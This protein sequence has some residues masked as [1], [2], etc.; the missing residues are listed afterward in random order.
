MLHRMS[1]F[2]A[3]RDMLHCGGRASL[4]GHCGHGWTC[5]L[6]RPVAI[7]TRQPQ[8]GALKK[9]LL[10]PRLSAIIMSSRLRALLRVRPSFGDV[11]LP[12]LSSAVTGAGDSAPPDPEFA[13]K[14]SA[15]A[16]APATAAAAAGSAS[17]ARRGDEGG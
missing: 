16:L 8:V 1:R 7:D 6:P 3:H 13:K 5:S 17:R 10:R 12:H 4:T 14:E 9:G 15:T 11:P 2:L